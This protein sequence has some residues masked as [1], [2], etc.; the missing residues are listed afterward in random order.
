LCSG[1]T[2]QS[3]TEEQYYLA[4]RAHISLAE[5]NELPDFEREAFISMVIKDIKQQEENQ[6][7]SMQIGKKTN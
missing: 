6:K 5:S 7:A 3:I 2:I 4:S 1:N